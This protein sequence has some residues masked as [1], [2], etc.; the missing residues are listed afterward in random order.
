ML[1]NSS[2][3]VIAYLA[4][5]AAGAVVVPLND[6]Y[7]LNEVTYFV[8][9]CGISLLITSELFRPL[10]E[11][12]LSQTRTG[13]DLLFAEKWGVQEGSIDWMPPTPDPDAPVMYQF[14]SGFYG[15]S[16]ANRTH[17]PQPCF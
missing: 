7:A 8:D 2:E 11:Q 9:E 1:P 6:H 4:S 3:F 15:T 5:V 12:V 16:Q 13:S 17:S 14:S 10:C